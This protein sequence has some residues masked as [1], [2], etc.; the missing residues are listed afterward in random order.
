MDSLSDTFPASTPPKYVRVIRKIVIAL[1]MAGLFIVLC[2][3]SGVGYHVNSIRQLS[4]V[5][6]SQYGYADATFYCDITFNPILFPTYWLK[7]QGHT[8]GTFSMLYVPESYAPGEFGGAN[9][10][11]GPESHYVTYI[12]YVVTSEFGLNLIYCFFVPFLVEIVGSRE[13]YIALLSG[14]VGFAVGTIIGL[15]IGLVVGTVLALFVLFKLSRT[16][17]FAR[18]WRSL[19]ESEP[20]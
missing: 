11:T 5:T 19:T 8:V 17:V 4:F 18:F 2:I 13:V 6:H 3:I 20:V 10:G 9:W 14:L 7:G 15:F 12:M 16:G 1:A